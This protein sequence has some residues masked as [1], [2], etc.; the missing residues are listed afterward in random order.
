[1][2]KTI[3]QHAI[4][5]STGKLTPGQAENNI[6]HGDCL[7]LLPS[8]KPE[9]VDLIFADPPFN[10]NYQYDLYS[11]DLKD[12]EYV[13]F[14]ERWMAACMRV[15]KPTGSFYIAIGDEFAAHVRLAINKVGGHLRNWIIWHV[16]FGQAMQKKFSRSHVHIFYFTKSK[17][18]L[19]FN[20]DAVRVPSARQTTYNDRRANKSGKLPDDTWVLRPQED[21]RFFRCDQDTWYVPRVCGT[22][23]ERQGWHNCQMPES[24]LER[25]IKA[26]SDETDVVLDPFSGSGTTCAV[27]SRLGRRY[28]GI[29][30]SENYV[31]MSRERLANIPSPNGRP[32]A[33]TALRKEVPIMSNKLAEELQE[34]GYTDDPELFRE[35]LSDHMFNAYGSWTVDDLLCHPA[36]AIQ[37]CDA[38]RTRFGVQFPDPLILKTLLNLRKRGG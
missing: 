14:T 15:L 5:R 7:E 6:H 22:F 24:L 18:A 4:E 32:P 36:D 31:R 34:H 9:S 2:K 19:K 3:S 11:D 27:A 10:I 23:S 30:W 17:K 1:M 8:L 20:A 12:H 16:T 25:I 28:I 26:S 13:V 29:E 37:F 33:K 21:E 35:A 38:I